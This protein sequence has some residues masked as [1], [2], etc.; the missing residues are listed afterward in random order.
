MCCRKIPS[1]VKPSRSGFN[2]S[3]VTSRPWSETRSGSFAGNRSMHATLLQADRCDRK[4]LGSDNSEGKDYVH[5]Q[6]GMNKC[7]YP[8]G[9]RTEYTNEANVC[10]QYLTVGENRG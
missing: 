3:T 6:V 5:Y 2:G 9:G 8:L 7:S 1:K 10:I 4:V